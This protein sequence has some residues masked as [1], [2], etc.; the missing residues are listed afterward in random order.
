MKKNVSAKAAKTVSKPAA[1]T[2][3]KAAPAKPAV[4][5]QTKKA[6]AKAAEADTFITLSFTTA[7][8]KAEFCERFGYA[9]DEKFINGD[10]FVDRIE[11]VD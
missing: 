1:K 9:P 3:A 5:T 4:K 6:A 2:V 11:L 7:K 8:A 10:V